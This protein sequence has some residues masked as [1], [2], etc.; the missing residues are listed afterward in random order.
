MLRDHPAADPGPPA[1]ERHV[2]GALR[3]A[4]RVVESPRRVGIEGPRRGALRQAGGRRLPGVAARRPVRGQPRAGKP[5][6]PGQQRRR[7]GRVRGRRGAELLE[8]RSERLADRGLGGVRIDPA[9][10]AARG[11]RVDVMARMPCALPQP[12][13]QRS[14]LRRPFERQGPIP[15]PGEGAREE[16]GQAERQIPHAEGAGGGGCPDA[17]DSLVVLLF[18]DP[19]LAYIDGSLFR[20]DALS[21]GGDAF[22]RFLAADPALAATTSEKGTF[23]TGQTAFTGGSVFAAVVAGIAT[24]DVLICDDLGDE[25]ADFIGVSTGAEPQRIS[26]YHA[27]HGARSLSASAFHDAIGQGIKNLGRMSMA[28]PAMEGKFAGWADRYGA[29]G[30]QT[31]IDRLVRGGPMPVARDSIEHVASG[32]GTIHRVVLLTSSLSRA[33]VE[34]QFATLAAGGA[35][36]PNFVQLYWLLKGFFSACAEVGVYGSV[37]CRP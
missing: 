31:A 27:K 35:V 21:G 17:A 30:V 5:L 36:R 22:L 3:P 23:A 25:W 11:V 1:I 10:G 7:L 34:A 12:H 32:L 29:D 19:A 16:R 20:D 24:E 26:F 18:D 14:E 2:E 15:D 9:P 28:G 4:E 6:R 37:I 8:R 13:L 33:D